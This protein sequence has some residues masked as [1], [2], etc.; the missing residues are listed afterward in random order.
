[1][2][3]SIIYHDIPISDIA[4]MERWHPLHVGEIIRRFGPWIERYDSYLPVAAPAYAQSY[5]FHNWRLTDGWWRE[6][7]EPGPRGN[8]SFTLPP[9]WSKVA[10]SF[11]PTQATVDFM[12]SELQPHERNVLRWVIM[13][14][15]PDG[16]DKKEGEDWFLNVHAKEV[17]QQTGLYRFFGYR[18]IKEQFR[19]PGSWPPDSFKGSNERGSTYW[20]WVVEMWYETFDDW[21]KSIIDSPPKYSMPPWAKNNEYPFLEPNIDFIST[22][23][24]ERPNDEFL[25]DSRY[26]L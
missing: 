8:L 12:G 17:M 1:M 9:V 15:F 10:I 6:F 5:G 23:I 25:R 13:F 22:F 20:D 16:V 21:H 19:L 18:T 24:L 3:R 26:Y 4:S 2:I 11:I 14:R 7:P